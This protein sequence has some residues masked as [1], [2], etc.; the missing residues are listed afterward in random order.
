[1]L[2]CNLADAT[3]HFQV[4]ASSRVSQR[5]S[6]FP[7]VFPH[8]FPFRF[9][10]SPSVSPFPDTP[11]PKYKMPAFRKGPLSNGGW[12]D[13]GDRR[14]WV[15]HDPPSS[16]SPRRRQKTRPLRQQSGRRCLQRPRV[17]G[18]GAQIHPA[19]EYFTWG[20]G[21]ARGSVED[22]MKERVLKGSVYVGR[23]QKSQGKDRPRATSN[24][25]ENIPDPKRRSPDF[26]GRRAG[27]WHVR[28]L[29]TPTP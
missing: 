6:T 7:L 10:T 15:S 22:F 8:S 14:A 17:Q 5:P 18:W 2:P 11:S 21:G 4:T 28:S 9:S 12:R 3:S 24:Q 29:A 27:S 20:E 26:L 13:P 25:K 16:P 19:D 23:K 1:M